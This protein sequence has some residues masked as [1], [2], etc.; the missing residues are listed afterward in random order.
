VLLRAEYSRLA[1]KQRIRAWVRLVALAAGH[2]RRW[3]AVTL[4]RREVGRGLSRATVGPLAPDR[5]REVLADLVALRRE[6]LRAPLPLP[7]ATGCAYATVRRGGADAAA[8]LEESLRRWTKGAGAERADDAHARVWGPG[9]GGL[10]AEPGPPGGEPTRFGA[11]ALRLWVPLLA[12][13]DV[14]RL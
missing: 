4:G 2:D 13:E 5:A 3:T 12:A 6:G 11:L 14:V 8:A 9:D 1:A 7:T 10:T